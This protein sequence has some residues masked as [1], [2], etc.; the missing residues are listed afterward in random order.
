M[1]INNFCVQHITISHSINNSVDNKQ[2][3][4]STQHIIESTLSI[5][6]TSC[7]L[8]EMFQHQRWCGRLESN[9]TRKILIT[10]TVYPKNHGIFITLSSFR[11]NRIQTRPEISSPGI[12]SGNE[13]QV[14]IRRCE[15]LHFVKLIW[16]AFQ[17]DSCLIIC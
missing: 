1:I 9:V 10:T 8:K 15:N 12:I 17:G 11:D 2:L 14:R 16:Q 5:H 4:S 3:L 6:L 13:S 7:F